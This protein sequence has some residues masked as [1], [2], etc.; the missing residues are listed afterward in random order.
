[1]KPDAILAVLVPRRPGIDPAPHAK[2]LRGSGIPTFVIPHDR[3]V[4]GGATL[5]LRLA[6]ENTQVVLGELA[7][8]TMASS[9]R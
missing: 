7:A 3:H 1:M 5:H 6:A 9:G 8:A 4:A 2:R